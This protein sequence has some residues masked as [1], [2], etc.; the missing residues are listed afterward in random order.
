[1]NHACKAVL[2]IATALIPA[3][4]PVNAADAVP[5]A[6]IKA[7]MDKRW[8]DA[9]RIYRELL[10]RQPARADLLLRLA[11]VL[12]MEGKARDAAD[13]TA[14]A[15]DLKPSDAGLQQRASEAYGAA[16]EPRQALDYANRALSLRPEDLG[17]QQ[18][19][20]TLAT[21]IGEY[22]QAENSLR[23]LHKAQPDKPQW[24]RD[25]GRVLGWQGHLDEA[26][27]RLD[28]YLK[29]VPDDRNA[30]VDLARI[31]AWR[32]NFAAAAALLRRYR[33]AGGDAVMFRR[34]MA[35]V[36]AWAGRPRAALALTEPGLQQHPEDYQFQFARAV[37][38]RDQY[39][40]GQALATADNLKKAQPDAPDVA[41]LERSIKVE[42]RPY[43]QF[44]AGSRWDSD[45]L[46]DPG[47][48]LAWHQPV[49]GAAWVSGGGG[50]DY[51]SSKSGSG[52]DPVQGGEALTRE[53]GWLGAK[54]VL[55][56]GTVGGLRLG[57]MGADH[58][59]TKVYWLAA[60][61]SQPFDS[62]RI[63]LTNGRDFQIVS[64]RAVSLGITRIDTGMQLTWR[65]D[66][67]WTIE[68]DLRE[69][70]LSDN[71]RYFRGYLAPRRALIRSLHWNFD[72]GV[73][74]NWYG[75]ETDRYHGYYAPAFYQ[76]YAVNGYLYYKINQED[77]VSLVVALGE[78]TDNRMK[79]FE[80]TSGVFGEATFG[81]FSDWTFRLR[82]GYTNNGSDYGQNY[83]S[84]F[85]GITLVRR[86]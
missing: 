47:M 3:M 54:G 58:N 52:L 56:P 48:E 42:R 65:P 68:T 70:E 11:D 28:D 30:M 75:Y 17:L 71:N 31:Q 33:Q 37:A 38:L 53:F 81:Q 26:A 50:M 20:A 57:A 44:D 22:A 34:E 13:A 8:G 66:L 16:G 12:A 24:Q 86:F 9:E 63:R 40:Y 51:L 15:A 45:A 7:E 77:G 36:Q 73:S 82:A 39:R 14:R 85:A 2:M 23:I 35:L 19:R 10:A 32:G 61:D 83:S 67:N 21:W 74:G 79:Q 6:A 43:L 46:F 49:G 80:F 55:A 84:V 25:L 59:A 72:L 64:P 29:R 69:A 78:H 62:L 5:D 27:R 18:R 76:Q 41:M 4:Q 60:I 1:M